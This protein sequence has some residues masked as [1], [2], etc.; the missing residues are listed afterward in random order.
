MRPLA[1]K[2][3][4]QMSV[5]NLLVLS[6]IAQALVGAA[7]AAER[8]PSSPLYLDA[9]VVTASRGAKP[10]ADTPVRTLLMDSDSIEKLHSRDIRDALRMLPGIQLREIHGKTGE[11]IYLQG[12]NGDRV[13][14]LVDGL[15]VSATTGSTVDTSQLSALDVEQI[16]V[17]PGA[18]SALYGSAA[19]GGVINIVTRKTPNTSGGRIAMQA[20]TFGNERELRNATLPQRH[21][22]AAGHYVT[23]LVKWTAS[24]DRRDSSE[25]DLDL[26]SYTSNGFDGDKTQIKFGVESNPQASLF[27]GNSWQLDAE[28]YDENLTN[29]RLTSSGNTGR[30]DETLKRQRLSLTGNIEGE[31]TRWSYALLHE[32]QSDDTA[33]LN[34]DASIPAGNLWRSTDYSQQKAMLQANK[35]LGNLGRYAL[36]AT[37]GIEI[38]SESIEQKKSEIKLTDEGV[39]SDAF[40]TVLPSG[41][42]LINTQEVAPETRSSG[43]LFAQLVATRFTPSGATLEWSPGARLQVDSDFG[44][45]VAPA[46]AARQSWPLTLASGSAWELQTRESL[47]VGYRVPNLKNRYY[48]FDHSINGYKVLGD[49]DLSP[50]SSRSVQLSASLT[51]NQDWNIEVSVFYNRIYDLI[52]AASSGEY[53]GG[54]SVAIYRYTNYANA[55]TKG[56]EIAVQNRLWRSLKQ[57]L[58]Y[59]YLDAQDLD[60]D[61]PLINRAAHHIKGFWSWQIQ[62]NWDITL[63]GEYQ[64][65]YYSY[66][67]ETA[68]DNEQSPDILRWDIKSG[69][70]LTNDVR[71]F[72]G[73]N[74]LTDNVRVTSNAY[75]RRPS[76]GR[77]PYIGMDFRF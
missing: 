11:E 46:L 10:L 63:T 38:F 17:I 24:L 37:S 56:Y 5:R 45:Y 40:I 72:G 32:A 50:E 33:Q 3:G 34:D 48:V 7:Q 16:E 26:N 29:R 19:M 71:L 25:F 14:I 21:I 58:S 59:S 69:F 74:N 41:Y 68:D 65:G 18:A 2:S 15:P 57:R 31:K 53:E 60:T 64:G 51:D 36:E 20:G 73:V 4:L 75:D 22:L 6:C 9:V 13:L 35:R 54:G 28:N 67:G 8:T 76:E 23:E 39:A 49:P 44:P 30:L 61:Q 27:V 70:Q 55:M 12:F 47:G 1:V 42:Y 43:E 77:F 66:I 62:H 52:E